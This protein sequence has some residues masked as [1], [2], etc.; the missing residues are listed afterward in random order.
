MPSNYGLDHHGNPNPHHVPRASDDVPGF[1]QKCFHDM[2]VY[3]LNG[4]EEA[5]VHRN[6]AVYKNQHKREACLAYGKVLQEHQTDLYKK[7]LST[8]A[9]DF[10]SHSTK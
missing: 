4:K 9:P 1:S 6:C 7:L 10:T 2:K 5:R 3:V 8:C